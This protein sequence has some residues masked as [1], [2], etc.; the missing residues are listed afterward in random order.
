MGL[1]LVLAVLVQRVAPGVLEFLYMPAVVG[2]IAAGGWFLSEALGRSLSLRNGVA[3][4]AYV[5]V[6]LPAMWLFMLYVGCTLGL[7]CL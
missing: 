7:D 5:L 3:A 2:S 1:G 6:M 4:I